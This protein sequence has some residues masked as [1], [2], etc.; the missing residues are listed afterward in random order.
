MPL[1]LPQPLC[2]NTTIIMLFAAGVRTP[3][4]SMAT[5]SQEFYSTFHRTP[6][7][8]K[9]SPEEWKDFTEQ[10][11]R[12]AVAE[13]ASSP[14]FT[15]WIVKN[16]DRLQLKTESSSDESVGSGSDSTEENIAVSSSGGGGLSW[17]RPW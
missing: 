13:L 3:P 9:F 7:K 16:A 2:Y 17:R 12:Q 14:E 15:D 6:N 8:K 5:N 11:T 1:L 4:S 10:S